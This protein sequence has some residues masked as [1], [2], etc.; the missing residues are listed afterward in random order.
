MG[1]TLGCWIKGWLELGTMCAVE[2]FSM[3]LL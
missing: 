1:C 3:K 2:L